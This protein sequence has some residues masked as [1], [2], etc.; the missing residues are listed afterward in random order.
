MLAFLLEERGEYGNRFFLV[1][2][3]VRGCGLGVRARV[4]D[5][6]PRQRVGGAEG[7]EAVPRGRDDKMW[8]CRKEKV[9]GEIQRGDTAW[10]ADQERGRGARA[11]GAGVERGHGWAW[12]GDV[13]RALLHAQRVLTERNAFVLHAQLHASGKDG[14]AGANDGASPARALRSR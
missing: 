8:R 1:T 3:T 12:R 7:A 13:G 6:S 4:A 14:G 5:T 9:S 11:W 2:G 10:G